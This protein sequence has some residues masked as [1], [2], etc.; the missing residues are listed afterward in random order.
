VPAYLHQKQLRGQGVPGQGTTPR[1]GV[2]GQGTATK[3]TARPGSLQELRRSRTRL[4]RRVAPVSRS[5]DHSHPWVRV[6]ATQL[7]RSLALAPGYPC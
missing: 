7:C 5:G 1:Q 4:A 6:L 3:A 2:T